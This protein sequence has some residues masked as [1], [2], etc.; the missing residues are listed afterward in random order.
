MKRFFIIAASLALVVV[1]FS[2]QKV[3]K[4]Y[5]VPYVST[6]DAKDITDCEATLVGSYSDLGGFNY[7]TLNMYFIISVDKALLESYDRYSEYGDEIF[8][9]SSWE[10]D[11]FSSANYECD[12]SGLAPATTYYYFFAIYDSYS[13]VRG[14]IHSFT[15]E[16]VDPEILDVTFYNGYYYSGGYVYYD[17]EVDTN[18]DMSAY[19][20]VNEYGIWVSFGTQ[21]RFYPCTDSGNTLTAKI[22]VPE[23]AFDVDT[24]SYYCSAEVTD[25]KV[26]IYKDA[27]VLCKVRVSGLE[28]DIQPEI[29]VTAVESGSIYDISEEN[30]DKKLDYDYSFQVSGLLFMDKVY[31]Y[32]IGNWTN[33]GEGGEYE[34]SA[35]GT[36]SYQG[37]IKYNSSNTSTRTNYIQL[38]A[39]V[40]DREIS[41]KDCIAFYLSGTY[42][43]AYLHYGSV[44]ET[45]SVKSSAMRLSIMKENADVPVCKVD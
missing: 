23:S 44:S 43:R 7:G 25:C 15:T 14:Q 42:C 30:W 1:S 13:E 20:D 38:R 11:V 37:G 18:V 27:E 33:E 3:E 6:L 16:E 34:L 9:V 39:M 24:E 2:C 12:L 35:D 28:Y 21:S 31:E 29:Q 19:T 40:G 26:G 22:A 32:F 10:S 4:E 36:Y 41:S 8:E 5:N 45:S 17:V